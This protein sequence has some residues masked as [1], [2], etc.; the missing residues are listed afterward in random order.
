MRGRDRLTGVLYLSTIILH[1][2]SP[3]ARPGPPPQHQRQQWQ[4]SIP[5]GEISALHHIITQARLPDLP[6]IP[7]RV[8]TTSHLE[9]PL[10][11][12]TTTDP[13]TNT[14]AQEQGISRAQASLAEEARARQRE[15]WRGDPISI[16]PVLLLAAFEG[17]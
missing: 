17:L 8:S 5:D 1:R 4:Q 2:P 15:V 14:H 13:N 9:S 7:R 3:E 6:C 12:I 11:I 16:P 10:S